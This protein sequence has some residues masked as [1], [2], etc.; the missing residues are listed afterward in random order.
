MIGGDQD[1]TFRDT[2][3]AYRTVDPRNA[4]QG[5]ELW[6]PAQTIVILGNERTYTQE[7]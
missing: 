2:R 3:E 4:G 1:I 7:G 6:N 5:A